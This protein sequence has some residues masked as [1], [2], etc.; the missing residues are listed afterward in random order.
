MNSNYYYPRFEVIRDLNKCT[1]CRAC[2]YQ[3]AFGVHYYSEN[4]KRML[5]DNLKCVNCNR[6]VV[7]CKEKA[8]KIFFTINL[9]D[10]KTNLN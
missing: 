1:N 6:C 10:N 9:L 8:I 2:E 3:C 4:K 7:Y 5:E